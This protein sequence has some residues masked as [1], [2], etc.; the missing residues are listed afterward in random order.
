MATELAKAYVQIIPS[1]QGISGSISDVLNG[2]S[3]SAGEKSGAGLAG[4]LGKSLKSSLIKLGIGKMIMDSLGNT[5]EF[6]TGMAKV[7]TLFKGTDAQFQQLS[8]DVMRLSSAYGL[9]ATT[10]AEAAYSAE[11][12]GIPMEDLSGI[13][14]NS[15]KL[16]MAGFTDIDTALSAT[17]KTMNAYGLAGEE[18]MDKVSKVLMQTQNLGITTVGEL[19]ASLANV[20]P[21]AAAMGVSFEQVGAAMAQMTAS[22]VPTAQATTQLRAA[23][24]ELGKAGTKA[25][26][27]FRAAT[28]DTQYA[29][30]S[31]QEAMASGADLGDVFGMM[32]T[33]AD[34]TGQSMVDLWGSVEAGNAAMLIAS[35]VDTFNSNLEQ[36]ATDADV[37]GDAYG[38]MANTMGAS[39]N[40]LK[41]SAKNF[42]TTL[43]SGGDISA[44]FDSMLSSLGDISGKLI[45]WLG[46][47]LKSLGQ[48]LPQLMAGLFDFGAG[49]LASLGKINWIELGTTIINGI[50]N[51]LGTLGT[52]LIDLFGTAIESIANGEVDFG[53][54]GTAIYNGVTSVIT[55][56]GTWLRTLFVRARDLSQKINFNTL[57]TKILDGVKSAIDAAGEFLKTL[58]GAGRDAA[59]GEGMN[60]SGIGTAILDGVKSVLDSAGAFLGDLFE[61]G[62]QAAENQPWPSI[63]DVIKTAVNLAL[64]GGEFLSSAFAAGAEL[65]KAINWTNVGEHVEN[66][67]VTGLNGAAKLVETVSSAA[68]DM[69]SGVEWDDVGRS[70]G[71]LITTGLESAA[72]LVD[73]L[74]GAAEDLLTGIGWTEIGQGATDLINAGFQTATKLVL[75]VG[76]AANK[77]I[78]NIGWADIGKSASDLIVGGFK[79]VTGLM[80]DAFSAAHNFMVGID[81]SDVGAKVQSGLGNV[82]EGLTGFLGG[83]LGGAG[84]A[85]G[86]A[87]KFVGKGFESL[88]NLIFGDDMSEMK[89]AADDLKQAMKDMNSALETGKKEL[90]T[91]A[92]SIGTSIHKSISDEVSAAK[93]N[94]IGAAL[95]TGI[96][97]GIE[98]QQV[99]LAT[100]ITNLTKNMKKS[101]EGNQ[102]D[103]NAIGVNIVNGITTGLGSKA[104]DLTSKMSAL[105]GMGKS[106]L[107]SADWSTAGINIIQGIIA[108]LNVGAI[109]LY[110]KMQLIGKL[111][112]QALKKALNIGSPSKV[113]RDQVG[114]WIPAGIAEGISDYSGV[115]SEALDDLAY[116][117]TAG[118]VRTTLARQNS[119]GTGGILYGF[120]LLARSMDDASNQSADNFATQNSLLREQNRL[121]QRILESGSG[122][123]GASAALGRTV[124]QSL[125]MYE[126]M[127]G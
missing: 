122:R 103:W 34:Q 85:L 57:G 113:M 115:V 127:G 111:A 38:K 60:Y 69:I 94:P 14:D 77:L 81:W 123:H 84:E 43:F 54:I 28:K 37:V 6:E 120:D 21:T 42:M 33:Y 101:F 86:G 105:I 13:L 48:N 76:A 98:S 29:G 80:Q 41:E 71:E 104:G 73:A 53:S 117:M 26:K 64:N 46:N 87:G 59:S 39:M 31:F 116:G 82:W 52:K 3:K 78:T 93:M 30:K 62:L 124:K 88:T 121:L 22:G 119:A 67:I 65:I 49:L 56:A 9:G 106:G 83:A 1:A 45:E 90:D 97:G 79:G 8:D 70:A 95:V 17:A 12:A 40:R 109:M 20:T 110:A 55:T 36:M 89:G 108:G 11:S 44:S 72:D 50:I 19:G 25:D 63:G 4:S 92:K 24:T 35:D 47:G 32:Q 5:S 91:T 107:S 16:A 125:A 10:L 27:A 118:R 100:T 114:R 2:E 51:G 68:S 112:V 18:S 58:F 15:A 66:L 75:T 102:A 96:K 74:S 23:M 7:S 61:S 99:T 126:V